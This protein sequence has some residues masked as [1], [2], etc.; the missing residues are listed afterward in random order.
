M[1]SR[2]LKQRVRSSML[3]W[4]LSVK[5][6]RKSEELFIDNVF[7]EL[8]S[9]METVI[10]KYDGSLAKNRLPM[11]KVMDVSSMVAGILSKMHQCI[12]RRLRST[13]TSSSP[14][15]CRFTQEVPK[16]LFD[17]ILNQIIEHN[18][19]GHTSKS[20]RSVS[21]VEISDRRKAVYLINR[22]DEVSTVDESNLFRKQFENKG[23]A[24]VL[25]S[26]EKP[27]T[28][29]YSYNSE[30]LNISFHYGYWNSHG[31]PQH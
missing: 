26:K 20:T 12:V 27:L 4:K 8:G 28:L 1:A 6:K 10:S 30:I 2:E 31:I 14:Y 24:E 5:T 13:P 25:F 11:H 21:T 29:K 15:Y 23:R 16:E 22:M 18:S 17:I 19:F 3:N 9:L 7:R